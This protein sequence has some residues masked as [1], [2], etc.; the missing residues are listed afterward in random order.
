MEEKLRVVCR[1]GRVQSVAVRLVVEREREIKAFVPEEYW[2]VFAD[3]SAQEHDVRFEVLKENVVLSSRP[4]KR[5][6]WPPWLCS[7]KAQYRGGWPRRQT[8]AK[9]A[10]GTIYYV[11]LAA[12]GEHL[13]LALGVKK[14]MMLAP[15]LVRSGL[16]HLHAYR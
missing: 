13:G 1:R 11:N 15:A 7:E 12:S 6:P 3:L 5:K 8:N 16:Y 14:T 2:Q 9:S 10:V 4:T